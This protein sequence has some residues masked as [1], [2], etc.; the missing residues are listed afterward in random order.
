MLHKQTPGVIVDQ[1]TFDYLADRQCAKQWKGFLGAMAQ[2][3]GKH[4]SAAELRA[5]MRRVGESYAR[6]TPLPAC[7]TLDDIQLAASRVWMAQDWGWVTVAEEGDALH[8]RHY[9]SPLSAAFGP[10]GAAWAPAF[11]EGA[12]QQWFQQLGAQDLGVTQTADIDHVGCV[13]FRLGR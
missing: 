12:Y 10:E 4:S 7:H 9:C 6:Q 2:E 8:L 11:L 1:T 5:L 3:F 13:Q